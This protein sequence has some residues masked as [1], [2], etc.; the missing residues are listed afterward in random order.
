MEQGEV[1]Q[2][3]EREKEDID[4]LAIGQFLI[5]SRCQ[6]ELMSLYLDQQG[7]SCGEIRAAGCNYCR[8]GEEV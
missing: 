8:E 5:S 4:V 7:Q 6:R 2:V 1:E 3:I